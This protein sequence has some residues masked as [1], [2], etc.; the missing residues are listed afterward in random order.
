MPS[1]VMMRPRSVDRSPVPFYSCARGRD[2]PSTRS[3]HSTLFR[4]KIIALDLRLVCS[5]SHALGTCTGAAS[6][7]AEVWC[8]HCCCPKEQV[9]VHFITTELLWI[10]QQKLKQTEWYMVYPIW[11]Q[12][13]SNVHDHLHARRGGNGS[14]ASLLA[15]T[16][17]FNVSTINQALEKLTFSCELTHCML[18]VLIWRHQQNHIISIQQSKDSLVPKPD[19]LLSTTVPCDPDLRQTGSENRDSSGGVQ[20]ALKTSATLCQECKHSSWFGH[21]DTG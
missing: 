15:C 7:T 10:G 12:K 8:L 2:L 6:L 13:Y 4:F 11:S 16:L 21:K 18:K 20:P 17:L 14:I 1:S 3:R 19:I 5:L 9:S